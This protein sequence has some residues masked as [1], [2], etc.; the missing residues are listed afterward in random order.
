MT[1]PTVGFPDWQQYASWR[2]PEVAGQIYNVGNNVG[3]QIA[4]LPAGNYASI[5]IRAFTFGGAAQLR[6]YGENDQFG[7]EQVIIKQWTII[8]NTSLHCVIPIPTSWILLELTSSNTLGWNGSVD[9]NLTNVSADKPHYYGHNSV[10]DAYNLVVNAG[11]TAL[12]YPPVFLPGPAHL[13]ANT[14]TMPQNVAFN[15]V[16][17]D[18]SLVTD[19]LLAQFYQVT[20]TNSNYDFEIPEKAW[21]LEVSNLSAAPRTYYFAVTSRGNLT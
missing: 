14:D 11:A 18:S 7:S 1:G 13:W 5:R 19:E 20:A 6:L 2:G 15:V 3:I 8:P 12:H 17:F 10:L 9:A 16:T 4:E 21:R